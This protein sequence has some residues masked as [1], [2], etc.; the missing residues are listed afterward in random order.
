[1]DIGTWHHFARDQVVNWGSAIIIE[2]LLYSIQEFTGTLLLEKSL[3]KEP[4]QENKETKLLFHSQ[5]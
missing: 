4:R 1:M 2:S 5:S 3:K